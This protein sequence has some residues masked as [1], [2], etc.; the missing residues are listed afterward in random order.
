[1]T[2]SGAAGAYSLTQLCT[3]QDYW[4]RIL[5]SLLPPAAA[6]VSAI[7][8]WVASRARSTYK[9]EQRTLSRLVTSVQRSS[10]ELGPNESRRAARAPRKSSTKGTTST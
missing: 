9:D 5:D 1:M 7:A 2:S 4:L 8:L 6:L 3:S 10:D